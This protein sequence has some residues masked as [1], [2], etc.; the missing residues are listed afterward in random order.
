MFDSH[1]H[2]STPM[3]T[4]KYSI[5]HTNTY[6]VIQ[7][8]TAG[9]YMTSV[10]RR[11]DIDE[12]SSRRI[13]VSGTS[14]WPYAPT[15]SLYVSLFA[16]VTTT[17]DPDLCPDRIP[18]GRLISCSRQRYTTCRAI[19]DKGCRAT[20]YSLFCNSY[21]NWTGGDTACNCSGNV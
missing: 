16:E 17:P 21:G 20:T 13:D 2:N 19:C 4:K 1:N 15:E 5:K 8:N 11:N 10:G 6:T 18:N 9:R 3:T 14:V 12:T 7:T